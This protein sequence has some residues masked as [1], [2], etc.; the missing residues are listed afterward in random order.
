MPYYKMILNTLSPPEF[1][2]KVD[3]IFISSPVEQ[4]ISLVSRIIRENACDWILKNVTPYYYIMV[5]NPSKFI[6]PQIAAN[7]FVSYSFVL[8]IISCTELCFEKVSRITIIEEIINQVSC[9]F[10]E[11]KN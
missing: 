8:E 6:S 9:Y 2:E 4:Q 11:K 5:N 7:L 1:L 10:L 3:A